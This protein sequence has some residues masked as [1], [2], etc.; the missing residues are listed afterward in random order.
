[1]PSVSEIANDI[2]VILQDIKTF[3]QATAN[4]T[5]ATA[6]NVLL[7]NSTNQTGFTN[8]AQGI[9]IMI[10]NQVQTNILLDINNKQ[11]ETIICWLKNIADLL[12][13][14]LH[15]ANTQVTLQKEI[16]SA[17]SNINMIIEL[18]NAREAV[19]VQ[20]RIELNKKIEVCCPPKEI[21]EEQ[22]Y[23]ECAAPKHEPYKPG[24]I[25]WKPVKYDS[26]QPK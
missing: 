13:R 26:K 5:Q 2:K 1:M 12:C 21:P 25:D 23:D 7:V 19:E 16:R 18:V 11:N 4:N 22:C 17:L 9:G 10:N 24:S 6:N 3:S 8:V 20:K 15:R 14:I